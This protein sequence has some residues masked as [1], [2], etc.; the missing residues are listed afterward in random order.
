MYVDECYYCKQLEKR[1]KVLE[2]ASDI[3]A[4]TISQIID[5]LDGKDG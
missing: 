1:V 4:E 3:I 5:K 2:E